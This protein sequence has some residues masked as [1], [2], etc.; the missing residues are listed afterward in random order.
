MKRDF[1]DADEYITFKEDTVY[2]QYTAINCVFVS[3]EPLFPLSITPMI[4]LGL[5]FKV[6]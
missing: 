1:L 2:I 5:K 6:N 4:V 3:S